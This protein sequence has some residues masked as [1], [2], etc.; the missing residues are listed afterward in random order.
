[1][2]R[3]SLKDLDVTVDGRRLRLTNLNKLMWPE[4]LTKA[5]LIKYYSA[6]AP[7]ILLYLANRPLVMKRYPDGLAGG[8]FYQ[9]ECPAYAPLWIKRQPVRHGGK[10][11]NYI[12]CND[13]AT[14]I[15]LANQACIEMHAW[16]ARAENLESP[17]LAVMDLDPAEGATFTDVLD[18][19]LMVRTVLDEFG[20][21]SF[22]KTSGAGGIHLF[23]PVRP[24]YTWQ[25][26]AAA[27]K[28]VAGIVEGACPGRATTE[29]K[30]EKR[31]GKVYL[32]YLQNAKGK[33]M[34]FQYSLRPLPGAPV[35]APLLWQEVE[36]R[37]VRPWQF[38]IDTIFQRLADRGDLYNGMQGLDQ[39]LDELIKISTKKIFPAGRKISPQPRKEGD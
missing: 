11:V 15:W 5:D 16:P 35:S 21:K 29:R 2:E 17:D 27:M 13:S 7:Y 32:D 25:Q 12:V 8:A 39:S 9:K 34:A 4:G 19:A 28:C 37:E 22:P 6:V 31:K 20:L 23:I 24:C 38:N 26:V 18:I 33:T 30:V 14:L 3:Q 10:V 36:K 1:M